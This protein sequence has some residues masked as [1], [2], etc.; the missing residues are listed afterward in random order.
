MESERRSLT[1]KHD[2]LSVEH[3]QVGFLINRDQFFASVY[4]ED[5]ES[6]SGKE[7]CPEFCAGTMNFRN[8][9]ILVY[10]LDK[11]LGSLFR[12]EPR[13]GLKIAL[14]SELSQFSE[15][16]VERI[17]TLIGHT[18]PDA[19]SDYIAFRIGSQAE[20][21]TIPLNEIKLVPNRLRSRLN[22]HGILGCRFSG[23]LEIYFFIDIDTVSFGGL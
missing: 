4:L 7:L 14:I 17:K 2:F 10:E 22:E 23:E 5:Y 16:T 20:I 21:K 8:E 6:Y 15:K 12:D 1:D 18:D 11:K 19:S 13:E 3:R 9:K